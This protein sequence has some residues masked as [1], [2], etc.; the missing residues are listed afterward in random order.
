MLPGETQRRKV[1]VREL[2]GLGASGRNRVPS[3]P[4]PTGVPSLSRCL[5]PQGTSL[6]GLQ[7]G[8]MG[9]R[10][11][12][13]Y[14]GG[15][16]EYCMCPQELRS[17]RQCAQRG[18]GER[19]RREKD[20]KCKNRLETA[21]TPEPSRPL[22]AT[23][24]TDSRTAQAGPLKASDTLESGRLENHRP[25]AAPWLL[26]PRLGGKGKAW[27]PTSWAGSQCSEARSSPRSNLLSPSP[28][29]AVTVTGRHQAGP[30]MPAVRGQ[31][32]WTN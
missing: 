21:A 9:L 31:L 27:G 13:A 2:R 25:E 16:K 11:P 19:Q 24:E 22:P 14:L 30:E 8:R 15:L 6:R 28:R 10:S 1:A 12:A 5:C 29:T 23:P 17:E 26:A 20:A 32:Y 7:R 4:T 3:D 18:R